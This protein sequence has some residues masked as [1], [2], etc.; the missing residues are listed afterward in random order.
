MVAS[1][2]I[3]G[4]NAAQAEALAASSAELRVDIMMPAPEI[5]DTEDL[6]KDFAERHHL[7]MTEI[8]EH[9]R[10]MVRVTASANILI[11]VGYAGLDARRFRTPLSGFCST[12]F[13]GTSSSSKRGLSPSSP[14][15]VRP[16][17]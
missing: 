16:R 9:E 3:W 4:E 5:P 15:A 8:L 17:K 6:L 12:C 14:E 13:T 11:T 1:L 2:R 10:V 7:E